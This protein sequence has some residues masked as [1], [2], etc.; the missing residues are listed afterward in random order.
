MVS[1]RDKTQSCRKFLS[2]LDEF[3][4]DFISGNFAGVR[5]EITTVI[6]GTSDREF[7]VGK[8]DSNLT[9]NGNA[10]NVKTLERWFNG[11]IDR[12]NSIIVDTVEVRIQNTILTAKDT[13]V[14]PKNDLAIRS[15][16]ASSE[17]DDTGLA[18][19]HIV[20]NNQGLF[21]S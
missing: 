19:I 1:N 18:A 7:T 13:I 9:V 14:A 4:Q 12:E 11:K 2:H 16:Y 21:P 8:P 20:K 10:V 3:D 5:Q 15:I 17:P 6:E